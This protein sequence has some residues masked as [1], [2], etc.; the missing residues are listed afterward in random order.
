MEY[1]N[2]IESIN[3]LEFVENKDQADAAVKA[4]LGRLL[5]ALDEDGA[6]EISEFLPEPLSLETLRGHQE[7]NL[8]INRQEFIEEIS[9]E[10]NL[11]NNKAEELV[12]SVFK[13]TKENLSED[14]FKK[15]KQRMPNE[16]ATFIQQ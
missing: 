1:N 8:K 6:K 13:V 4:T 2:L 12:K 15:L 14:Q 10:F 16:L 7:N 3:N 5:S 9:T 11:D